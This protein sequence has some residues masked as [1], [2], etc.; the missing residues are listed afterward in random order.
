MS[1]N[2]QASFPLPLAG[3]CRCGRIRYRVTAAPRFVFACHCTDCQQLTASA[4]SLGMA[5]ADQGFD[6]EGKL[7]CWTKVADSGGKSF[8]FTCP[9]CTGWTHTRTESFA[10]PDHRA[11][12]HPRRP[13][14]GA[15]GGANLHAERAAV[16]VDAGAVQ[17]RNRIQGHKPAG[18]GVRHRRDP[19][20]RYHRMTRCVPRT[21]D[22]DRAGRVISA[23]G[24]AGE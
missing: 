2:A 12:K 6:L 9:D 23:L 8:Q 22:N 18:T 11:V 21:F 16:G 5:V 3:K 19:A 10:G 1:M 24:N 20:R 17:L 4:F 15:P 13:P 7:H 14:V